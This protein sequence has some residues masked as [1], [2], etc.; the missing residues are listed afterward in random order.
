[1]DDWGIR[2]KKLVIDIDES[3]AI[4]AGVTNRDIALSLQSV[5]NG[6]SVTTFRKE[7]KLIPVLLRSSE[8]AKDDIERLETVSVYSQASG[9]I[10]RCPKWRA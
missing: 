9:K 10:Y 7:D 4:K 6:F 8:S 3:K 5:S 2:D 1:M